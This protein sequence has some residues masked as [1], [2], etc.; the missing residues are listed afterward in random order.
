M[1]LVEIPIWNV[2][3]FNLSADFEHYN[4][5][6]TLMQWWIW[7]LLF[8]NSLCGIKIAMLC[9]FATISCNVKLKNDWIDYDMECANTKLFKLIQCLNLLKELHSFYDDCK[10]LWKPNTVNQ[11]TLMLFVYSLLP[12]CHITFEMASK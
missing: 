11:L 10:Y 7:H 5:I 9:H 2:M 8:A 4:N 12:F 6:E 3:S 1:W